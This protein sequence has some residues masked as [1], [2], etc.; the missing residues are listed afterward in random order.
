[1]STGW[2]AGWLVRFLE[3]IDDVKVFNRQSNFLPHDCSL[4]GLFFPLPCGIFTNLILSVLGRLP[5]ET[6]S[7]GGTEKKLSGR[8]FDSFF[9]PDGTLVIKILMGL[10]S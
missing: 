1:M 2:L 10:Y 6:E 7:R 5:L 9:A 4:K 8:L 3:L